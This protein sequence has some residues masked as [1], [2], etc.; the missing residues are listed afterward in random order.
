MMASRGESLLPSLLLREIP[1]LLLRSLWPPRFG[2]PGLRSLL[3]VLWKMGFR[4]SLSQRGSPSGGPLYA[5]L[6]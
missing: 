1:F 4:G 6:P 3:L 2:R 5:L